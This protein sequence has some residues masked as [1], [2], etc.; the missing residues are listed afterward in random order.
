MFNIELLECKK[1]HAFK[2][3]C[4]KDHTSTIKGKSPTATASERKT[5]LEATRELIEENRALVELLAGRYYELNASELDK[6]PFI[7]PKTSLT[8]VGI[9]GLYKAIIHYDPAKDDIY[10][11]Y[12]RQWIGKEIE[13]FLAK[14]KSYHIIDSDN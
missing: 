4:S 6:S 8:N 11:T 14:L 9:L 13:Y 2:D 5:A 7:D 12:I 1:K 10:S 3:H